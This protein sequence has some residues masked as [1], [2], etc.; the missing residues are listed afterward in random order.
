MWLSSKPR[1]QK[2]RAVRF[3]L[4]LAR[5][6]FRL[7]NRHPCPCSGIVRAARVVRIA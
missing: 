5:T 3:G 2:L 1:T 7:R 4:T 6:A